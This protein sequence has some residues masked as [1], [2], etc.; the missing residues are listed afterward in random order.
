[1]FENRIK[2]LN[3]KPINKKG[4]K[5]VYWMQ[6][7]IRGEYN[8]ALEYA[9][10][11]SNDLKKDLL[12]VF[13]LDIAYSEANERSFYFLLE[14]LRDVKR[15]LEE[16]RIKFVVLDSS[17]ITKKLIN[18]SEDTACIITDRGYLKGLINM[19]NEL[20]EKI[21]IRL[22][23]VESD[24][25]VPI[26]IASNK[27]EYSARTIRGKIHKL[28][29]YY[30]NKKFMNTNYEGT[31]LKDEK[32]DFNLENI[33]KIIDGLDIDKTV[34]KTSFSQGGETKAN[35]LLD[36]FISKKLDGYYEYKNFPELDYQSD[37][38][39]YLHFGNIS[40]LLI[41]QKVLKS[42][43]STESIDGFI[44]ELVIRRELAINFVYYN[45]GYDKFENMTY[46]W[47]YDTMKAHESDKR[48]YV[49]SIA[50]LEQA[51]THD[52]YW[53]TA[54]NEM[55]IT[56][57]MHGYMRMYWAKKIIEWSLDYKEAYETIK[58]LNNKYFL[59]GRDENGYAGIAWCFGKHDRA[60][61]QREIFG[62]LRYMNSNGLKSKFNIEEYV[63]KI[64]DLE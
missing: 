29:D 51:K 42:G 40:P 31:F 32:S 36:L 35:E 57:K 45:K 39:P 4:S 50:E 1:M 13:G 3:V 54:Q 63:R 21:E 59:D 41:I 10:Q 56:G 12:V 38:S 22:I 47:A 24:V 58:Y 30:I 62:K 18:L 33:D 11:M 49:Y 17:P 46:S 16:K 48:E 6:R 20:A 37:L 7:S 52:I 28:W 26:E 15:I 2:S 8:H 55:T 27:E 14:S 43:K 9:I 53:N 25:V 19:R 23:Q 34:K 60:W 5:I 61:F 44:E 64:K